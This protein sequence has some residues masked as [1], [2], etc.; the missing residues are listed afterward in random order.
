MNAGVL[1]QGKTANLTLWDQCGGKGG[2]CN[3]G[4][5]TCIDGPFPN[6]TCPG[7][8]SCLKQ[9]QW[10]YQCLPTEGYTCIPT[11]GNYTPGAPITPGKP[12]FTFRLWD[13]CG[14]MGGNCA[15]FQCTDAAYINY[16]CPENSSC[17]RQNQWCVALQQEPA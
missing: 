9:S 17:Q 15:N 5:F 14:G 7:N 4:N 10:Y 3:T 6:Y 8:S 16:G 11:A 1:V 12:Q 2:N 13:Q